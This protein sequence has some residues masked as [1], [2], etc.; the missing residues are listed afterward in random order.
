M[1]SGRVSVVWSLKPSQTPQQEQSQ[2]G[3]PFPYAYKIEVDKPPR[4][5]EPKETAVIDQIGCTGCEACIAF[6]P[7][8]CI[9]IVPGPEHP[10]FM[11]LV[12]VDLERCIGC[13]LCAR[14]C[15]W[16]TIDMWSYEEGVRI[17]P[18][19]TVRTL[20]YDYDPEEMHEAAES[21]VQAAG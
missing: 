11:K 19:M 12:E 14:Y 21:R 7:V 9:E 2:M 4:A 8:D 1:I 13:Q 3:E 10:D 16:E 18:K 6:C 20:I 5:R 15:P 17:A